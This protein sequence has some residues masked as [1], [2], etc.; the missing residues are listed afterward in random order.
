MMV[1]EIYQEYPMPN[2]VVGIILTVACIAVG[3]LGWWLVNT[4]NFDDE[5]DLK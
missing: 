1:R 3:L 4:A 5:G 2:L